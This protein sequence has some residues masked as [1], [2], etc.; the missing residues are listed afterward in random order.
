[1]RLIQPHIIYKKICTTPRFASSDGIETFNIDK[2]HAGSQYGHTTG[3]EDLMDGI[4]DGGSSSSSSSRAIRGSCI[5]YFDLVVHLCVSTFVLVHKGFVRVCGP[6]HVR[7]GCEAGHIPGGT[8]WS[9][10][11]SASASHTGTSGPLHDVG[12]STGHWPPP[13]GQHMLQTAKTSCHYA[14]VFY[15]FPPDPLVYNFDLY[16]FGC[17]HPEIRGETIRPRG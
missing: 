16:C 12:V 17:E 11:T 7:V 13:F 4:L 5:E 3:S 15:G 9:A 6:Y 10:L 14:G 2:G 1:M 8:G